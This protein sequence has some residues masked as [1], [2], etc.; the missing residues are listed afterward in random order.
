MD[1]SVPSYT[2]LTK[3]AK[4]FREGRDINNHPQSATSLSQ[5]T[6]ENIK[7]LR[8]VISNDPHSTYDEITAGTSLSH[9]TIQRIIH[10]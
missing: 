4:R 3:W 1:P 9:S 5:V 8:Q 2:T 7:L 6:G 10:H